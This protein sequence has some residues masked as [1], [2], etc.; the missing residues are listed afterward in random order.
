MSEDLPKNSS[1]TPDEAGRAKKL[2]KKKRPSD[3]G[4]G[5]A[6]GKTPLQRSEK[7][8][9]KGDVRSMLELIQ[10]MHDEL[11]Q[12]VREIHNK[13]S[14]LPKNLKDII[15]HPEN[16]DELNIAMLARKQEEL[17]EQ[18]GGILGVVPHSLLER[19]NEKKEKKRGQKGAK[20]RVRQNWLRMD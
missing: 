19:K 10:K 18:V 15:E 2:Q 3:L 9:E 17:A 13:S 20:A 7:G 1:G 16:I 5:I 4:P 6:G 14:Y 8:A 12:K 11:E